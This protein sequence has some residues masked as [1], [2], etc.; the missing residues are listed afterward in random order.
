MASTKTDCGSHRFLTKK[1]K[2][3]IE[4]NLNETEPHVNTF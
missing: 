3:E 4:C 2:T 1:R